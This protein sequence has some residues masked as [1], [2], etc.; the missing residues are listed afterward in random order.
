ML[1]EDSQDIFYEAIKRLDPKYMK[2]LNDIKQY[3][4][5]LSTDKKLTWNA[6]SILF[7]GSVRFINT[8]Q[9][10]LKKTDPAIHDKLR[11]EVFNEA[12]KDLALCLWFKLIGDFKQLEQRTI[13]LETDEDPY[14]YRNPYFEEREREK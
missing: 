6:L 8:M 10:L 11:K 3:L 14:I 13:R 9:M 2:E 12:E 5:V 4:E 7:V 1:D